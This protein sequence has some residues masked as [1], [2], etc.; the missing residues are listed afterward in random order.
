MTAVKHL[1]KKELRLQNSNFLFGGVLVVFVVTLNLLRISPLAD[2]PYQ[3]TTLKELFD[4]LLGL[5]GF[6]LPCFLL[7]LMICC[8]ATSAEN[9][10]D[11]RSWQDSLPVSRI[12]AYF[13]KV[14]IN[15]VLSTAIASLFLFT[16]I[17]KVQEAAPWEVLYGSLLLAAIGLY[18]GSITN[19]A[20][21][22]LITGFGLTASF[23]LAM[24]LLSHSS[25]FL[26]SIGIEVDGNITLLVIS[27]AFIVFSYYNYR[28]PYVTNIRQPF[29][30]VR[31][32]QLIII[33]IITALL[34]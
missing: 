20:L 4:I 29:T 12:K 24:K 27:S 15:L 2:L 7:P 31:I 34:V 28:R 18:S 17:W 25:S 33:I 14:V 22:A 1:I 10:Y 3:F 6:A 5:F 32:G 13:I 21:K 26:N 9:M 8:S 23:F 16:Y 11:V 30:F 19:T